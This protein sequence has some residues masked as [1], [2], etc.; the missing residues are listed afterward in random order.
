MWHRNGPIRKV[1][2]GQAVRLPASPQSALSA[3][4]YSRYHRVQEQVVLQ[5]IH[6]IH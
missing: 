5:E 6:W 1:A 3:N 2:S 4:S